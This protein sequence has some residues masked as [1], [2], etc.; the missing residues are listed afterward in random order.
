MLLFAR[1]FG[2]ESLLLFVSLSS[3][4]QVHTVALTF[5][6][7]PTAETTDPA[8]AKAINLAILRSLN[9][10]HAPAIGFVIEQR[11]QEIGDIP[12]KEILRQWV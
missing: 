6:D 8:E 10:R 1:P 5:D 7:L 2:S 11:V 3:F 9:R 4:S 12:G